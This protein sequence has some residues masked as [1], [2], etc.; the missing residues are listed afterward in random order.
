LACSHDACCLLAPA[1]GNYA[2]NAYSNK[3]WCCGD[4]NHSEAR[5]TALLHAATEEP[6]FLH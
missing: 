1:A 6:A 3:R 5:G 2:N 4:M